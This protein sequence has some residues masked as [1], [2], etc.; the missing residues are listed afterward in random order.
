MLS[1]VDSNVHHVC[2]VLYR[3]CGPYSISLRETLS[4]H[5][6]GEI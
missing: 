3:M 5:L 6:S 4:L 1:N 2:N